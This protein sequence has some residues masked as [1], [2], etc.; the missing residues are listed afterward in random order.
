MELLIA[1]TIVRALLDS[2]TPAVREVGE[3]VVRHLLREQLLVESPE[4]W[5][6]STKV[7]LN[8]WEGRRWYEIKPTD[9]TGYPRIVTKEGE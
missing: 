4:P 3:D 9:Y 7:W 5:G 6:G 8:T 2:S 1:I